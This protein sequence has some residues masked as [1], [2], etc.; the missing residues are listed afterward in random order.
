[1]HGP[2][3]SAKP[4]TTEP[5]KSEQQN[6]ANELA[7]IKSVP[8]SLLVVFIHGFKGT[9]QTFREF[10]KRLEHIL[11]ETISNVKVECLVFPAYEVTCTDAIAARS[12]LKDSYLDT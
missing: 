10:P 4:M 12:Q 1:M 3:T 6:A 8:D 11:S 9:D 2:S 7:L 5:T